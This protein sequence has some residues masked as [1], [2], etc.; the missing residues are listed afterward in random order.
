MFKV[1]MILV[2][3]DLLMNLQFVFIRGTFTFMI[4][5]R[6]KTENPDFFYTVL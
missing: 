1:V 4:M 3:K 5:M 6:L 2:N